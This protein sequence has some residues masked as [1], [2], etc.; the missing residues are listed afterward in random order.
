MKTNSTCNVLIRKTKPLPVKH[1]IVYVFALIAIMILSLNSS[2]I[3]AQTLQFKGV[4]LL[5]SQ[6]TVPNDHVWKIESCMGPRT[7]MGGDANT[8]NPPAEHLI[9]INGNAIS[10]ATNGYGS[11]SI[12][13]T[14]TYRFASKTEVCTTMPIWLPAGTIVNISTNV[15]YISIVEFEVVP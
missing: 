11:M 1:I 5:S 9:N 3:Q 6:Q 14:S 7:Y 4:I 2:K 13:G 10:V 12:Y 8:N 15:N